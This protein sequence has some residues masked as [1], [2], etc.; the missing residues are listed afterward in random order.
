[1]YRDINIMHIW[2]F[3]PKTFIGAVSEMAPKW[4]PCNHPW[5]DSL[6]LPKAFILLPASGGPTSPEEPWYTDGSS[7]LRER[8][9]LPMPIESCHSNSC[10]PW[11]NE[12]LGQR[13][14]TPKE[15][16]Y[17]KRQ[18]QMEP[19]YSW[20]LI[21]AWSKECDGL[22]VMNRARSWFTW[23][24]WRYNEEKIIR[25]KFTAMEKLTQNQPTRKGIFGGN[26][27]KVKSRKKIPEFKKDRRVHTEGIW[28]ANNR[29]GGEP[30]S[31]LDR[32]QN[33]KITHMQ[34]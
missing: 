29:E 9:W 11:G 32:Q 17:Q 7:V 20:C 31:H 16:K 12:L 26:I 23:L 5:H 22:S 24:S 28:V 30:S 1:M 14:G 15:S 19:T 25:K 34:R 21:E 27:W 3:I 6:I 2:V 4:K 8:P 18:T 33:N 10:S 13:K